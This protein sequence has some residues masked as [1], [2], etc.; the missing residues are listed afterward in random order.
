MKN[1]PK[2]ILISLIIL[3]LLASCSTPIYIRYY[4]EP[5]PDEELSILVKSSIKNGNIYVE[6][7]DGKPSGTKRVYGSWF[8]GDFQ[9]KLK[10]G[11][12]SLSVGYYSSE[13]LS[14]KNKTIYFNAEAGKVYQINALIDES[15]MEWIPYVELYKKQLPLTEAD[16]F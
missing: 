4:G 10:P 13:Y 1:K 5:L 7:V 11:K 3:V 9:I 15:K 8:D 16:E 14:R 2:E 6:L 12:H